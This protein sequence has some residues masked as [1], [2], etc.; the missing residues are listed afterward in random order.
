MPTPSHTSASPKRTTGPSRRKKTSRSS[1][2]RSSRMPFYLKRWLR[3]LLWVICV[4]C[5]CMVAGIVFLW[6]SGMLPSPQELPQF[7][8]RVYAF[9]TRFRPAQLPQA[10]VIGIDIS[11]YQSYIDWEEVCF[12]YDPHHKLY[13]HPTQ[14]TQRREVDFVIA[15]ATEGARIHDAF[16]HR[17]KE[18]AGK[19]NIPFGAYHFYSYKSSALAQARNFIQYA[20]LQTGDL[21]PV[22]DVEPYRNRLPERDSVLR[23]LQTVEKYYGAKPIIYTNENCY[24]TYFMPY[25]QFRGYHYWIARYG[26]EQP[27]SKHL[28][29][30]S[31]DNGKVAGIRGDVDLNVFR[32]TH[33]ELHSKY[34]LQ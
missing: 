8:Q 18:G 20:N 16:Y 11:H 32:G 6:Y 21:L 27:S 13:T 4:C 17:N 28:L 5:L 3:T 25:K 33:Q 24:Q 22:L 26:G 10:D 1:G 34:T 23:W 2:K 15:K 9:F 7:K 19:Q 14:K 29:W 12:L 30:Q 31:A